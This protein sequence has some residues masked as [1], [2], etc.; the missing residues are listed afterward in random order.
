MIMTV[1]WGPYLGIPLQPVTPQELEQIERN[2]GVTLPEEYKALVF[3]YQG[4][5][6]EPAVFDVGR[7]TNVFNVLLTVK[8]HEGRETYSVARAYEVLKPLVPAGIFPFATT[9]GAEFICFDYRARSKNPQIVFVTVE[10]FIYP[11]A[12]NLTD[13]LSSLHD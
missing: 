11:V 2:W 3:A 1:H 9:P 4:M 10:A 7:G 12:N 13:F 8:S 6:P 5:A